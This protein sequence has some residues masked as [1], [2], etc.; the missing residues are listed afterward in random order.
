[1]L[2]TFLKTGWKPANS[3][4]LLLSSADSFLEGKVGISD[5]FTHTAEA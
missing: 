5:N 3:T 4:L 2:V 1:V